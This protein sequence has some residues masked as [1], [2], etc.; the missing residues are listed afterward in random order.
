MYLSLQE[1]NEGTFPYQ[2]VKCVW[3]VLK[4]WIRIILSTQM[5]V[6][7]SFST[8]QYRGFY[9]HKMSLFVKDKVLP[10]VG[11]AAVMGM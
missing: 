6:W 8:S 9:S 10:M 1:K 4:N 3:C 7:H 11:T 2:A 5:F